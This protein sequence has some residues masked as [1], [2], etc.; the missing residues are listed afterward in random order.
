M[1]GFIKR[2]LGNKIMAAVTL[3]ILLVMGLEI[4]LRI[5]FGTRDRIELMERLNSD[6]VASTYSGIKYPMSVGDSEAV[7]LV[8][9]GVRMKMAG[10]EV[11]ICDTDQQ[12]IWSTH[13]NKIKTTIA[14]SIGNT[15]AL[16]AHHTTHATVA[17]SAD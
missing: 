10:V 17:L 8:L 4:V 15:V 3:S 14:D 16:E 6:L 1:I 9:A 13:P 5:Y 7:E 2:S 11:F 12:I